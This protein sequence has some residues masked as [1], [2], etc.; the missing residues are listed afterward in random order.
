ML[1]TGF[2]VQLFVLIQLMLP[3]QIGPI[4]RRD[5]SHGH[6]GAVEEED[7]GGEEADQGTDHAESDDAP[8]AQV[9]LLHNVAAQ[10][11]ASTSGWYHHVTCREGGANQES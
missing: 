9:Q 4:R 10:E 5:A 8:T 7:E 11:G 1:R 2:V 6:V 3:H